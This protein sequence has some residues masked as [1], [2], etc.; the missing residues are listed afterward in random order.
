MSSDTDT[1]TEIAAAEEEHPT[2]APEE[3]EESGNA[4]AAKYRK[5][6]RDTE[7]ERDRLAEQVT[8]LQRQQVDARIAAKGVKPAAVW[9]I[10]NLPDVL[11]EDGA[12][13]DDKVDA[14]IQTAR[15]QLGITPIGKGNYV[16]GVGN[17]P[18]APPKTDRW[19]EAFTPK[20]R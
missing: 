19:S 5:R 7:A 16:P 14:A 10:T 11:G 3:S 6:L 15:D 17:M 18:S 2:P 20:R 8:A 13:D 12:V 1:T 9:A 4:E